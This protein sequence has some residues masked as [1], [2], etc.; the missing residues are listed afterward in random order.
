MLSYERVGSLVKARIDS[1]PGIMLTEASFGETIVNVVKV[2]L[3]KLY[4]IAKQTSYEK[5][6]VFVR[7]RFRFR[8]R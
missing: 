2:F 6:K 3:N 8:N 1:T 4:T 5:N 7:R